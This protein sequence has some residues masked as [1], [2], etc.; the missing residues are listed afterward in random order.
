M[1]R[2]IRVILYIVAG[3]VGVGCALLIIGLVLG[4]GRLDL[5]SDSDI[6][7]MK[8]IVEETIGS[9]G[10]KD[11]SVTKKEFP[12]SGIK[13][14]SVNIQ[15]GSLDIKASSDDR[16]RVE[17]NGGKGISVEQSGDTL[18]ISD[19]RTGSW[20]RREAR[21]SIELPEE[22][23]ENV[24]LEAGA[25]VL[26]LNQRLMADTIVLTAGAGEI[27]AEY[28][29]TDS[30]NAEAGVGV[31]RIKDGL[32]GAARLDCGMGDLKMNAE[33]TGDSTVK[34][35]MGSVKLTLKNGVDSAN[36]TVDCGMGGIEVGQNSY[37]GVSKKDEIDNGADHT[38]DLDC[39][40]GGITIK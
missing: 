27:T 9:T 19:S 40:M 32:V 35:G 21:L 5:G 6:R 13:G 37:D 17:V 38:I 4:G 12:L 20:A 33:I 1:N 7:K 11:N 24:E 29:E 10:V 26:E 2:F 18:V 3:C 15:K 31:I 30:L 14:L 34:C 8:N 16:I 23:Y 25:G 39:G 22:H 28:V 36:Y